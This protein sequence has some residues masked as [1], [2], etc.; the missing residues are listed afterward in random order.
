MTHG[1]KIRAIS[2][3]ISACT[4]FEWRGAQGEE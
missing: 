4:A 2:D 3:E 1:Q